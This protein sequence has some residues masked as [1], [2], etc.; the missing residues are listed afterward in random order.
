MRCTLS[1]ALLIGA[2]MAGPAWADPA[3]PPAVCTRHLTLQLT[4]DVSNPRDLTF[5]SSLVTI[6]GYQLTWSGQQ[7]D[8]SIEVVLSGPGPED[9]CRAVIAAMRKNSRVQSV[10]VDHD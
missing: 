8:S 6:P 10:S 5:L 9:Q 4:P 3:P 7:D 2:L 1:A